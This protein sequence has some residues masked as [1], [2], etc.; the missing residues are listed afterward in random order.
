[1]EAT[2]WTAGNRNK[3]DE[4]LGSPALSHRAAS[5]EAPL[6][7]RFSHSWTSGLQLDVCG[8]RPRAGPSSSRRKGPSSRHMVGHVSSSA[9]M[10]DGSKPHWGW[11]WMALWSGAF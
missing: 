2:S 11:R 3:A 7:P 6:G 9:T 10:V 8:R 1:M 5:S 4:T